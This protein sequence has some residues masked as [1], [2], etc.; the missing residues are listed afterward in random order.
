MIVDN[1]VERI[2]VGYGRPCGVGI[3]DGYGCLLL[4]VVI[5]ADYGE[6]EGECIDRAQRIAEALTPKTRLP[7]GQRAAG[8]DQ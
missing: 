6:T 3:T 8:D 5:R 2:D 1:I 7:Q 4:F